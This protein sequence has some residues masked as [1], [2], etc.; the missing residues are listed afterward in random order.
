MYYFSTSKYCATVRI[1]NLG[2][3]L[4]IAFSAPKSLIKNPWPQT[5]PKIR[6]SR[7][8][9]GQDKENKK[10]QQ[11]TPEL[12]KTKLRSWISGWASYLSYRAS[13]SRYSPASAFFDIFR[14]QIVIFLRKNSLLVFKLSKKMQILAKDEFSFGQKC[15]QRLSWRMLYLASGEAAF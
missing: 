7:W 8:N 9:E 14:K 10:C 2:F 5:W 4:E 3:D 11:K 13:R 12:H 15:L 6:I 1:K